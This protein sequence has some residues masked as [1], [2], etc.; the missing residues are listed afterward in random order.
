MVRQL[1]VLASW[2]LGFLLRCAAGDEP[3][4]ARSGPSGRLRCGREAR[5]TSHMLQSST[6]P[7][8]RETVRAILRDAAAACQPVL[9]GRRQRLVP[10]AL[11]PAG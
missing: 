2:G 10:A 3:L 1:T 6:H 7:G 11:L 8:G 9:G 5:P 4:S